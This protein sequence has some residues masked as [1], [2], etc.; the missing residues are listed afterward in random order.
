[1]GKLFE[2]LYTTKEQGIGLGLTVCKSLVELNGGSIE[3]ES[4]EGVGS[5]F[6]VKLSVAESVIS[7]Q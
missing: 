5:T 1:M 2:P 3:V 4:E 6:T 7:D